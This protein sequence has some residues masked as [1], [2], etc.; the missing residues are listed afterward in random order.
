MAGYYLPTVRKVDSQSSLLHV[1]MDVFSVWRRH[2]AGDCC[3]LIRKQLF[4]KDSTG[5]VN[6]SFCTIS[7]TETSGETETLSF[8]EVM[9]WWGGLPVRRSH[10]V[11]TLALLMRCLAS[12]VCLSTFHGQPGALPD[13]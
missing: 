11:G 6:G 5:S 9:G 8:Q 10:E 12:K 13:L 7:T 3:E 1:S 2:R 4:E